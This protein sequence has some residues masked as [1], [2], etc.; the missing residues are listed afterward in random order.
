[1]FCLICILD[2][3]ISTI[4]RGKICMCLESYLLNG[5]KQTRCRHRAEGKCGVNIKGNTET[6][7]EKY[8]YSLNIINLNIKQI[9][10]NH[11]LKKKNVFK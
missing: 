9:I 8:M 10:A 4:M 2:Y 1:M 3:T 11:I 5:T 6:Y 7:T